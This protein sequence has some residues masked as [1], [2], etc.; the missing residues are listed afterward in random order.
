[1]RCA[2][3]RYDKLER[4]PEFVYQ[5]LDFHTQCVAL[6]RERFNDAAVYK[7]KMRLAWEKIVNPPASLLGTQGTSEIL[8]YFFDSVLRGSRGKNRLGVDDQKKWCAQAID[9]WDYLNDKVLFM[10]TYAT[11]LMHRLLK[12]GA[13]GRFVSDHTVEQDVVVKLKSKHSA[14]YTKKI[15]TMFN[16]LTSAPALQ[17]RSS[18]LLLIF[19]SLHLFFSLL[20]YSFLCYRRRRI[21]A[22]R[23]VRALGGGKGDD[24]S[25]GACQDESPPHI[26]H[27]MA[28]LARLTGGGRVRAPLR[29]SGG[30]GFVHR[31]LRGEARGPEREVS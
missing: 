14:S 23:E 5:L 28:L 17:V 27:F 9:L 25:D 7:Q 29:S 4:T 22:S 10:E 6:V 19:F 1:M 13:G 24:G 21:A 15:E 20:I 12:T 16:D 18:F 11:H 26:A 3:G 8:S 2:A 31:I 30:A